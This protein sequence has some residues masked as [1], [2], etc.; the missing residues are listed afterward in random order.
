MESIKINYKA[1]LLFILHNRACTQAQ[2]RGGKENRNNKSNARNG[3][4]RN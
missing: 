1:T 3:Y 4:K 2:K